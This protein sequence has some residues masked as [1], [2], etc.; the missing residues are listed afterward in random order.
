M[1]LQTHGTW[2][3][4]READ[5]PA[6]LAIA[7]LVHPAYPEDESGTRE[8]L[9]L[10]PQG[11]FCLAEGH[12]LSGYL[13]SHPWMLFDVPALNTR[14]GD[15]P[16]TVDLW[17]LHDLALLPLARGSG[18][19]GLIVGELAQAARA[20]GFGALALVAVNGS[21]GFWERNGFRE[22]HDAALD[23]KLASYDDAARYMVRVLEPDPIGRDQPDR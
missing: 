23:R 6:V 21:N 7:T 13:V 5:L 2:R 11:C 20:A 18:A 8:R 4:M 12:E 15:L 1:N 9:A 10:A 16:D 17:Y 3:P 19:A 14:L 22:A